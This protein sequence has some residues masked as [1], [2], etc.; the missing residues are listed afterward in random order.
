MMLLAWMGYSMLLGALAYAAAS[1]LEHFAAVASVPRRF[2]W[3]AAVVCVAVAPVIFATRARPVD[4]ATSIEVRPGGDATIAATTPFTA[5]LGP[6]AIARSSIS[7]E[8]IARYV[9]LTLSLGY[10]ALIARA[11]VSLHRRSRRWPSVQL[12]ETR[13][14]IAG[15]VGPAVVGAIQPRIIIPQWTLSLESNTRRLMLRHETE[16]V[17]ARD[18]LLLFGA[19]LVLVVFPWNPM[20]WALVARL[21]LAIEIDCDRRVLAAADEP[22]EYGRLLLMVSARPA[23]RLP[24]A[25]SL[26]ERRSLLER[27]IKAMTSTTPRHPRLLSA[28]CIA[29]ALVAVTAAARAPRPAPFPRAA[30]PAPAALAQTVTPTT[31]DLPLLAQARVPV[32]TDEK[33]SIPK[34]VRAVPPMVIRKTVDTEATSRARGG[35]AGSDSAA[36]TMHVEVTKAALSFPRY[37]I[38]YTAKETGLRDMQLEMPGFNQAALGTLIDLSAAE[39]VRL[40]TFLSGE[41]GSG[42]LYVYVV[43]LR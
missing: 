21:R 15:D 4:A 24:L 42:T 40:R 33:R 30:S 28:A 35:S 12:D 6:R 14:L 37:S 7:A 10:L 38:D 8:S 26:T 5:S 1:A 27:R 9:W 3:A 2:F 20:L 32:A 22:L 19:T 41:V 29:I 36:G 17:R 18:P 16:H 11:A 39:S 31:K 43:R 23:V 13:V 25:A 34:V